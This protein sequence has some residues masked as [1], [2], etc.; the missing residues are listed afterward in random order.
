M[1]TTFE[2]FSKYEM[3]EKMM[4]QIQGGGHWQK[5]SDGTYTWIQ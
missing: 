4:S 5:E 1:K 2:N 3:S